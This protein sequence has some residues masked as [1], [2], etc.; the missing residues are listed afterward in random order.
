MF[1]RLNIPMALR[2]TAAPENRAALPS[3]DPVWRTRV[4][5]CRRSRERLNAYAYLCHR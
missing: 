1:Y 5:E 2:S 4:R 3:R